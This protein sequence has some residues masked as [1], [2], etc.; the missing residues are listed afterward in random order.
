MYS[1][2]A[3]ALRASSG[4]E[5]SISQAKAAGRNSSAVTVKVS[6]VAVSYSVKES[7]WGAGVAGRRPSKKPG[8]AVAVG[9]AA[10]GEGLASPA[11]GGLSWARYRA[12][13]PPGSS[14]KAAY[15]A[16][17]SASRERA[18]LRV[19]G[20]MVPPSFLHFYSLKNSF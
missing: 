14:V 17:N 1:A 9:W 20:D 7:S 10:A 11:G 6:P 5:R 3:W 19:C 15:S 12:Y 13:T 16:R 8:A 2:T 4:A 18:L